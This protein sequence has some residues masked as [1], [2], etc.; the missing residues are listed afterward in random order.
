MMEVII[1]TVSSTMCVGFRWK[2]NGTSMVTLNH[3]SV[4]DP[5]DGS[6][7]L[8]EVAEAATPT[9]VIHKQQVLLKTDSREFFLSRWRLCIYGI[10][11]NF[12]LML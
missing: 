1:T 8:P 3:L 7:L 6:P 10:L 11:W 9:P 5:D 4:E 2:Y 12:Y